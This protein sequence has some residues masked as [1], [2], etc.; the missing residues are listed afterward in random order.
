MIILTRKI[1]ASQAYS[2]WI[3]QY[4]D[5]YDLYENKRE[6]AEALSR[7]GKNPD[8]DEVDEIIGNGSWT[9]L[10]CEE[11]E[12]NVEK[13]AVVTGK[14]YETPSVYICKDCIEKAME[15]MNEAI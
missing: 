9:C 15:L 8:P 13:V 12:N 2:R 14:Q 7:L 4:K 1:L 3:E 11:C 10:E 5:Y 6:I